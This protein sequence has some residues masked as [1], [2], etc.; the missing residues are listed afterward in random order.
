MVDRS[1]SQG[2]AAV[3]IELD[4]RLCTLQCERVT[5]PRCSTPRCEQGRTIIR[6]SRDQLPQQP[7]PRSKDRSFVGG[8]NR[9]QYLWMLVGG[10]AAS[11]TKDDHLW[12]PRSRWTALVI[13][14]AL[15]S[16]LL[17]VSGAVHLPGH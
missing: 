3:P 12:G 13:I 7:L 17:F 11:G 9:R 8:R 14:A 2:L 1:W 5:A 10:E 15:L 6:M 4:A 16:F